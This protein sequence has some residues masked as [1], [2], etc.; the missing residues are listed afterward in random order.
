V[1][2]CIQS[3]TQYLRYKHNQFV[4][5]K[6]HK[7]FSLKANIGSRLPPKLKSI[8]TVQLVQKRIQECT[9]KNFFSKNQGHMPKFCVKSVTWNKYHTKD[10]QILGAIEQNFVTQVT[11]DLCGPA[12]TV[13]LG[14]WF[15]YHHIHHNNVPKSESLC[16]YVCMY[17]FIT[18]YCTISLHTPTCFGSPSQPSGS[19]RTWTQ[20]AYIA[21]MYDDSLMMA[22]MVGRNT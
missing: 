19:H 16:M 17:D 5:T 18:N 12:E 13:P 10:P 22:K 21:S 6:K 1:R 2:G 8:S 15:L 14:L 3:W 7:K 9:G 20:A 11:W 4:W